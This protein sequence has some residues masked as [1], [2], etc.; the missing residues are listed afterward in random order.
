MDGWYDCRRYGRAGLIVGGRVFVGAAEVFLEEYFV[1]EILMAPGWVPD[2]NFGWP[3]RRAIRYYLC[4][5]LF[6]KR[7]CRNNS[8]LLCW[9]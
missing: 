7:N 3:R 4:Y 1:K 8:R 2:G 6:G 5:W 9:G